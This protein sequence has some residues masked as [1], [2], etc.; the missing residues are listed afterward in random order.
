MLHISQSSQPFSKK[1]GSPV[2]LGVAVAGLLLVLADKSSDSGGKAVC[3]IFQSINFRKI[4]GQHQG[5]LEFT[6][7]RPKPEEPQQFYAKVP[8]ELTV[9]G[10]YHN[11]GTFFDKV[12]KLSRI[13]NV[14]DFSMTRRELKPIWNS[15]IALRMLQEPKWGSFAQN[16][17]ESVT[18]KNVK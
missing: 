4:K 2:R 16:W 6:L 3:N 10:S 8:I 15:R 18:L 14:V 1:P 5:N 17:L 13:I 7:F 9:V 12:G 11:T